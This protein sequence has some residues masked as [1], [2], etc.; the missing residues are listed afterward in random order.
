M[1]KNVA[2][3]TV[4]LGISLIFLSLTTGSLLAQQDGGVVVTEPVPAPTPTP[5]QGTTSN[6]TTGGGEADI[7]IGDQ[8]TIELSEDSRNQGFIGASA[9]RIIENGF[10]GA[11]TANSGPGLAEGATFGGGVNG[12]GGGGGGGGGRTT[13]TAGRLGQQAGFGATGGNGITVT[14]RNLRSRVTPR[15]AAPR[16]PAAEL[17]SRFNNTFYRLP[18][19]VDFNGQFNVSVENRT[20][21]ITGAVGSQADADKLVR[22]LRLQPGIYNINNQLRIGN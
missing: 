22:Q 11:A 6:V 15:F 5:T 8:V 4:L 2:C 16:I 19:A 21:T 14:R 18:Q 3:R 17:S 13:A 7:T 9:P 12:G 1:N 10:V 20:A